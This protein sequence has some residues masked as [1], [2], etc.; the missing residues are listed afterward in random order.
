M[1]NRCMI[2]KYAAILV[3]TVVVIVFLPEAVLAK[4]AVIGYAKDNKPTD[5]QLLNLTHVMAFSII[6]NNDGS[7]DI[8]KVSSW[9]N[10]TFVNNAHAKGVKVSISVGGGSDRSKGFTYAT[11]ITILGT[12]VT[13]IRDFVI[14]NNLDGV[15]IDWEYPNSAN[16]WSQCIAL[17]NALKTHND[18]NCKRISIALRSHSPTSFPSL[19]SPNLPVL[20]QIWQTV[21]AI[22]LM[23]Y[24]HA[25]WSPHSN[26]ADAIAVMDTWADWGTT[27]GRN[28]DKEK[29]FIGCAFYGWNYK[30]DQYGNKSIDWSES[31]T[32]ASGD[33]F[34]CDSHSDD[35]VSV[36]T[37]VDSCY[38]KGYGG[39]FIWHLGC[40]LV[41]T[42]PL[43]C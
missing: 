19:P 21:D 3:I 32:Y 30:I 35:L 33:S 15:D 26:A 16:E 38:T 17:L 5:A 20:Q 31:F 37:K 6:P 12:F 28:L 18:L 29:L 42:D 24:D 1:I 40:D 34:S 25:S 14:N 8:S 13:N 39:V 7:L 4:G 11:D 41:A 10:S 9:L 2:R 27:G 22:H 36:K 43:H 23:T